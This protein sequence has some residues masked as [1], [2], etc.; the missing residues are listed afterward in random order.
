M[1]ILLVMA[2]LA[3]EMGKFMLVQS[4]RYSIL[5]GTWDLERIFGGARFDLISDL[6]ERN[7]MGIIFFFSLLSR[8]HQANIIL[9]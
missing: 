3:L 8:D 9:G 6:G 2:L 5:I 7:V 4:M 1:G